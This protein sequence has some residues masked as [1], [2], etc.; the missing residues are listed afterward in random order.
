MEKVI[1]DFISDPAKMGSFGG[2][3]DYYI[4]SWESE[5]LSDPSVPKPTTN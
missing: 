4:K 2:E 1:V 3:F 5:K